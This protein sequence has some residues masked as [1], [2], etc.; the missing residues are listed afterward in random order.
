M[1]RGQA[2]KHNRITPCYLA[3]GTIGVPL[4]ALP[5]FSNIHTKSRFER[6]VTVAKFTVIKKKYR[7]FLPYYVAAYLLKYYSER[8]ITINSIHLFSPKVKK[9]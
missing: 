5:E 2:I 3:V 8:S 6:C 7:I 1:T 9:L 4:T